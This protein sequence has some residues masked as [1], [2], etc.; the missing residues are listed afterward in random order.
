[1][2]ERP[3]I[4]APA[5]PVLAA[6][7]ARNLGITAVD[8]DDLPPPTSAEQFEAIVRSPAE[9]NRKSRQVWLFARL[10]ALVFF[11]AIVAGWPFGDWLAWRGANGGGWTYWHAM[12]PGLALLGVAAPILILFIGY[13]TAALMQMHGAAQHIASAAQQF[14]TPSDTAATQAQSVGQAVRGEMDALN[15]GL[16]GALS[17]LA[18]VEAMIRRHVDAIESAGERIERRST[19]AM[20][21]VA[22]ERA[23]L[24]DLTE[25]LNQQAD[26]F[27]A[28]IAEKAKASIEAL[29]SADDFLSRAQGQLEDRLVKLDSVASQ[30]LRS[31]QALGQ[32]LAAAD[33]TMRQSVASIESS[34]AD[35]RRAIDVAQ[36]AA[37]AAADAAARNAANVGAAAQLAAQE[38]AKAARAAVEASAREVDRAARAAADAASR[39]AGRIVD[40]SAA[41]LGNVR[42]ATEAAAAAAGAESAKAL[43][44]AERV[45]EAARRIAHSSSV[46]ADEAARASETARLHAD[47]AAIEADRAAQNLEERNRRLAEARTALEAENT[48][49][50]EL[51]GE[52]RRRADRLADA[53]ATQ[54][55]RLSR[56]AETQIR[57]QEATARLAEA[58][59]KMAA[60]KD[61]PPAADPRADMGPP[62]VT[63]LAAAR[64]RR[65]LREGAPAR[66]QTPPRA[67]PDERPPL[68]LRVEPRAP[69]P[70]PERPKSP[71]ILE[72][73][74]EMRRPPAGAPVNGAAAPESRKR[75]DELADDI[76]QRRSAAAR[77][78]TPETPEPPKR[79]KNAVTWKE[80]LNSADEAGPLD[81]GPHAAPAK[82][83][84]DDAMTIISTLQNFTLDLERRLYGEPPPALSERFSRGDRNIFASRLLRLNEADVKR[85]LRAETARDK[86]FDRNVHEFLQ[87]FEALLEDATT[88]ETV[89]E[90]LEQYL[91]SPLGRVYLLIG[92]T[93]GYFA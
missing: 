71:D 88:S 30:A 83:A 92:A 42:E 15:L 67:A 36:R 18:A 60:V 46:A 79:D 91:S 73:G 77:P 10:M 6:R 57:E 22:H 34:A 21:V 29:H 25:Q 5:E 16:D 11:A 68:E 69:A 90:D 8:E 72:L 7:L 74:A 31:F 19:G 47:G 58:Q 35:T 44:A 32:A 4:S 41:A 70:P 52:Q 78:R 82:Q 76:A 13:I 84:G 38:A 9:W 17:R 54:T 2:N 81:L 64:A 53:I 50:E 39:E 85:R 89:D 80:I 62:D 93:V 66:R 20:T 14:L 28:A 27:A 3:Q 49:L 87:G 12:S 61:P 1:M 33:T 48:R 56:L 86:A 75:L 45:E 37:D 26:G 40:A 63:A 65:E 24:I 23:K 55:E 43:A 51:I 59:A